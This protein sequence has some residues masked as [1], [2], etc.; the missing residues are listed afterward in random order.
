MEHL[1]CSLM[2][3]GV[4]QEAD[5]LELTSAIHSSM[6]YI[7]LSPCICA[8]SHN[9][10]RKSKPHSPPPHYFRGK[11][12]TPSTPAYRPIVQA[13]SSRTHEVVTV[14]RNM[15]SILDSPNFPHSTCHTFRRFNL[16]ARANRS[17]RGKPAAEFR[18]SKKREKHARSISKRQQGGV[19]DADLMTRYML[20]VNSC[21]RADRAS[22]AIRASLVLKGEWNCKG[23]WGLDF[24]FLVK[25]PTLSSK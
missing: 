25:C 12:H 19:R 24:F 16:L 21:P 5:C 20:S 3:E 22:K 14:R 13:L 6:S 2:I 4:A 8:I 15:K 9:R 11:K 7:R 17:P 1:A 23:S 18:E 10:V